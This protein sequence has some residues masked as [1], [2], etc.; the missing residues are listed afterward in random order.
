[1]K[2]IRLR[3]WRYAKRHGSVTTGEYQASL[4]TIRLELSEIARELYWM[5]RQGNLTRERVD[6]A[7][8]RYHYRYQAVLS[9]PPEG[10]GKWKRTKPQAPRDYA[11]SGVKVMLGD[12]G[13]K[14]RRIK[15]CS[16][17]RHRAALASKLFECAPIVRVGA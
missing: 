10:K 2:G 5:H 15:R 11:V 13:L 6:G 7:G 8:K 16:T 14:A 3:L 17:S 9:N 4:K 12:E 1:M